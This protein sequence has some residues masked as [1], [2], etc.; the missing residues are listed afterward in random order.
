MLAAC[1]GSGSE[2]E[3]QPA[4]PSVG[5]EASPE[6][7]ADPP[8]PAQ[9]EPEAAPEVEAAVAPEAPVEL[10]PAPELTWW[11]ACDSE[12]GGEEGSSEL[13]TCWARKAACL[14]REREARTG[15]ETIVANSLTMRCK[16]IHGEPRRAAG[17]P[18]RWDADGDPLVRTHRHG[19]LLPEDYG[20]LMPLPP[21]EEPPPPP[22]PEPHPEQLESLAREYGEGTSRIRRS[23]EVSQARRWHKVDYVEQ[24]LA[25]TKGDE[26]ALAV[27]MG[28]RLDGAG[29]EVHGP[30][31]ES[32][33]LGFG[34]EAF[35]RVLAAQSRS[36]I[37]LVLEHI[38]WSIQLTEIDD[39]RHYRQT[40]PKTFA[41]DPSPPG[42]PPVD[43][44]R[45]WWCACTERDGTSG[46][47]CRAR[48]E[49]CVELEQQAIV[50][51]L[52]GIEKACR[53]VVAAHPGDELDGRE[54]WQ[55]SSKRGWDSAGA[56][57][58]RGGTQRPEALGSSEPQP[59]LLE[60][61]ARLHAAG[62]DED[63]LPTQVRTWFGQDYR[64]L[65]AKAVS[66]EKAAGKLVGLRIEGPVLDIHAST[67][68]SIMR[69]YG[70]EAFAAI[71][72]RLPRAAREH[73]LWALDYLEN[74]GLDSPS[75]YRFVYPRTFAAGKHRAYR[76]GD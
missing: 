9:Q 45:A 56:C 71:L 59:E 50:G 70:D 47:S 21:P 55:G 25:A 63:P 48:A 67:V 35:A 11:C 64:A 49:A 51:G 29:A 2:A 74:R 75:H 27:L 60:A 12:H 44:V 66:S 46:T 19:C 42:K 28:L 14:E 52:E 41:L 73:A 7:E 5:V 58:L 23:D 15:T 30:N 17:W 16:R 8:E 37:S 32:L 65:V 6:I 62:T 57:R 1:K 20:S 39:P 13:M 69:G 43:V 36:T 38:D 10:A 33:L 68:D 61:L 53:M 18:E 31:L 72:A 3:A 26:A 22:T 76:L 34:D 40:H 4:A 24:M 54:V